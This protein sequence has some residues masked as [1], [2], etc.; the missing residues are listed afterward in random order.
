M[1]IPVKGKISIDELIHP[2]VEAEISFIL[3]EELEGPDITGE[4]VMEKTEW[5]LPALEIIDSRYQNFKFKIPDVIADST[6]A[7][8]VVL[9]N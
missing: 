6:S 8:R 3:S 7:S 1:N 2:K 5:I 4:Q 9:G